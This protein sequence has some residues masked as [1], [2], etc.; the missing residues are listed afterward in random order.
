MTKTKALRIGDGAAWWGDRVEPA[1]HLRGL[2]PQ[3]A[4][5]G[6]AVL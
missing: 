2:G 5:S 4:P 3:P 1:G 6:S